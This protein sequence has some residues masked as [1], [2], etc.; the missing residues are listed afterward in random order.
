MNV[1]FDKWQYQ[2]IHSINYGDEHI[3]NSSVIQKTVCN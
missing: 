2:T 3:S 1:D